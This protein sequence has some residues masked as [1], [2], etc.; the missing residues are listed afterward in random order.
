M[1]IKKKKS[2]IA[3]VL[4]FLIAVCALQCTPKTQ[5][6]KED[7][8]AALKRRVQEYWNYRIRGEW[9]K[10]YQY[11]SP[12][13]KEKLNILGY[14]NQNS[15]LPLK[16]ERYDIVEMW[17]SGDEGYVKMNVKYR[18]IIPQTNKAAFEQVTEEKWI[19]KDNQWYRLSP[20]L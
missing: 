9:E 17:T 6:I 2:S 1:E 12:D 4:S 19:K 11:E 20:V 8:E 13:Y 7:E 3:I 15:R 18:F 10:S 14:I 16:W 5:V